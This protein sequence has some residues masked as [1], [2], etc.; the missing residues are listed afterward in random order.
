MYNALKDKYPPEAY[1]KLKGYIEKEAEL[2]KE[3]KSVHVVK[4]F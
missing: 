2:M 4:C 3:C 1:Q